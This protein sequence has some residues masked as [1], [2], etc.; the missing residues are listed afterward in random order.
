MTSGGSS[1]FSVLPHLRSRGGRGGGGGTVA[2]GLGGSGGG[3]SGATMKVHAQ[4][5]LP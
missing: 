5:G 4:Q 3:E 1:V 2:G